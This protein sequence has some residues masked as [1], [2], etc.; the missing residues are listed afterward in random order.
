MYI[1]DILCLQSY[2]YVLYI[3]EEYV[4]IY[5]WAIYFMN[6]QNIL[7]FFQENAIHVLRQ[8]KKICR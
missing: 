4:T 6:Y 5:E 7:T 3:K 2:T 1:L 8:Q